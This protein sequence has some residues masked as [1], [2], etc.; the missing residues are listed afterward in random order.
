MSFHVF[1]LNIYRRWFI[2]RFFQ[3]IVISFLCI[4]REFLFLQGKTFCNGKLLCPD[5]YQHHMRR[6]FHYPAGNGNGMLDP[7]EESNA[8]AIEFIIHNAGIQCYKAIPVRVSPKPYT[9]ILSVFN[10]HYSFFHRINSLSFFTQY[11]PCCFIS[12]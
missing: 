2:L 6:F 4:L 7:F 5:T 11:F 3:P 8:T 12:H 1:I 9:A 10:H